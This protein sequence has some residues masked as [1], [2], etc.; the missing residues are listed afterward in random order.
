[1]VVH[2]GRIAR[3]H[4]YRES[5]LGWGLELAGSCVEIG[6][7]LVFV[8]DE[9]EVVVVLCPSVFF[10]KIESEEKFFFYFF[11]V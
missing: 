7:S 9:C 5:E 1:M 6:Q 8:D 10:E 11:F 3:D 4:C 2:G